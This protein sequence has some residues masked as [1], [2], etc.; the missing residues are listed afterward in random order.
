M[1]QKEPGPVKLN[2]S[3]YWLGM[4]GNPGFLQVNVYMIYRD[5]VGVLIDPGPSVRF[6]EIKKA[7]ESITG[8]E[9]I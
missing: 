9:N 1:I 3:L 4:G 5:G 6:E 2:D 7:S 8:I